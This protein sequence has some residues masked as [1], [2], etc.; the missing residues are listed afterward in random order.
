MRRLTEVRSGRLCTGSHVLD[1]SKIMTRKAWTLYT[2]TLMSSFVADSIVEEAA[3]C[4]G[5]VGS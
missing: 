1:F 3:S 5:L 4:G 2:W